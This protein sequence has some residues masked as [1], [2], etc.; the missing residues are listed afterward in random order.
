MK[1]T[2]LGHSVVVVKENDFKGIIDP[3]ITGNPKSNV[4][5]DDL[6]DITHIFVT[7][8]HDDHLGDTIELANKTKALVIANHEICDYLSKLGLNTHAMHIGGRRKFDFGTVKMS[9]A[10]HG[11]G[12]SSKDEMIYGG[13]PCGFIIEINNKKIYH[14]GDT[15]LTLDM[16]LLEDENIDLAFLPIGGNFTMDVDDAVK[17]ADFIKAKKV[18]PIHYNTFGLIESDPKVYKNKVK[19]SEVIILDIGE[20]IDI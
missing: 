10:L 12:I 18:V 5:I 17:A 13:N 15:G 9:N 16:K 20:S 6:N 11:S 14:A 7:H 2:Y 4:S 3:F 1:L 8:G 19:T